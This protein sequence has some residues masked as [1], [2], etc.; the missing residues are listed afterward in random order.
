MHA[1]GLVRQRSELASSKL[2]GE[3]RVHMEA[4]LQFVAIFKQLHAMI[5]NESCPDA[6][7]NR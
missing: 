4:L 5:I 2:T 3:A 7:T 6:F 1:C